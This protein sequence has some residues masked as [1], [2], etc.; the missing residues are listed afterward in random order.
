MKGINAWVFALLSLI[1]ASCASS[2]PYIAEEGQY[3]IER[4]PDAEIAYSVYLIGDVSP[5]TAGNTSEAL[6]LLVSQLDL[7]DEHSAIVFLGAGVDCCNDVSLDATPNILEALRAFRGRVVFIPDE[8]VWK[9]GG[10]AARIKW[11]QRLDSLLQRDDAVLPGD[12]FPGPKPVELNDWLTLI[13]LDTQ[14]W[15]EAGDKPFGETDGYDLNEEE[16]FLLEINNLVQKER[17]KSLLVVGHHPLYSNGEYAGYFSLRDH[18]FP[19]RSIS[20]ALWIPAP[21]V[22]SIVPLYSQYAGRSPQDLSH[23][24]YTTLREALARIFYQHNGLIYASA[25]ENNL[26][27]FRKGPI[28][29]QQHYLVSGSASKT[30]HVGAGR[31]A[32]FTADIPGFMQLTYYED[33]AAWLDVWGI[34]EEAPNGKIMYS[35]A[36]NG[37]MAERVDIQVAE[38]LPPI[39]YKDSTVTAAANAAYAAGP[40]RRFFYGKYY[41]STWTQPVATPIFDLGNEMGG[42]QLLKRGG[43][44]QTSSLHFQDRDSIKYVLRSIEKT[45]LYTVPEAL[46][47][48]IVSDAVSDVMASLHPYGALLV[49]PLAEAAGIYHAHPKVVYV[50]DDP[51]LGIYRDDFAGRIMMFENRPDDDMSGDACV[52]YAHN[53]VSFET[54]YK[55]IE[56]D[57]DHRI[58][59]PAFARARLFDMLIADWDRNPKQWRWAAFE[60]CELDPTLE[61]EARTM[62]KIYRPVPRDRDWA[63]SRLD[64]VIPSL[65]KII[66]PKFQGFEHDYGDLMGLTRKGMS[67]DRRFTAE[68][69]RENWIDI[70]SQLRDALSDEVIEAAIDTWPKPIQELDGATFVDILKTRRD[71]LPQVAEA[72][73]RMNARMVDIVGSNKHELFE[74]DRIHRD[75]TRVYVYKTT[76][77]GEI[78]KRIYQR[79]FV[80]NETREIRLH[81]MDGKDRFV[82]KGVGRTGILVRAIGGSGVDEFIDETE[83]GGWQKTAIWYISEDDEYSTRSRHTNI[84][85]VDDPIIHNYDAL[86]FRYDRNRPIVALGSDRND[87]FFFGGGIE[88]INNGFKREPYATSHKLHASYAPLHGAVDAA[89]S[90]R[91]VTLLGRWHIGL[92]ANYASLEHLHNFY[93]FGNETSEQDRYR[94]NLGQVDLIPSITRIMKGNA[95]FSVAPRFSWSRL[96]LRSDESEADIPADLIPYVFDDQWLAGLELGTRLDNRDHAHIPRR[97]FV[98]N[99]TLSAHA[100][101]S[102]EDDSYGTISSDLSL[103]MTPVRTPWL[104][105]AYHAAGAHNVGHYPFYLANAL[106]RNNKLLGYSNTRFIGRTS[107]F[108]SLELRARIL[109]YTTYL[110]PG[111][112][113][114]LAAVD[115]GRV[116]T[117][118][119]TSRTWHAGYGVGPWFSFMDAVVITGTFGYSKEGTSFDLRL[120]FRY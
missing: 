94:F 19:L 95:T 76:K 85:R 49:P 44:M 65:V 80:R 63:F 108:H 102:G 8:E 119:E 120:G 33:G 46:R 36:L 66:V 106:G 118:G 105:F 34:P 23:P 115:H 50:P 62:G 16:D 17:K 72:Y 83:E 90:G 30:T 31:S 112:A 21:V 13:A 101:V 110:T 59:Q 6:N 29:N 97:G 52:G 69:T 93:G 1:L 39:E 79:T 10:L 73:Y 12:G 2:R 32:S 24:Q 35:S 116:W 3:G 40:L 89:Y 37:P 60:P 74:V 114:L 4:P 111:E 42:L 77:E 92:D 86:P 87:G 107:L 113:G 5:V 41:R 27:Y 70:A 81:G 57:N 100:G 99:N 7:E 98:W 68:L 28:R 84:T 38:D 117:D 75:T 109:R 14:W 88:F 18:L 9:R 54:L 26:Q 15:L 53:V 51:R 78:R 96:D 64:G 103:Y 43:G 55:N 25:H 48:T 45:T 22:G 47:G 11:Q 20:P 56:D 82:L 91:Y 71:Q 58:D 61:G 67:Q 104:T